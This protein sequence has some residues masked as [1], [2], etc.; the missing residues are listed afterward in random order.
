VDLMC[1]LSVTSPEDHC[2]RAVDIL[3]ATAQAGSESLHLVD[4]ILRRSSDAWIISN[5]WIAAAK[6]SAAHCMSRFASFSADLIAML[7]SVPRFCLVPWIRGS[8]SVTSALEQSS[9]D[10]VA[11]AQAAL[12]LYC[13]PSCRA[14]LDRLR[15]PSSEDSGCL[16]VLTCSMI[17]L[18]F[19]VIMRCFPPKIRL[20]SQREA[21][22]YAHMS[23]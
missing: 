12:T 20:R 7:V 9:A 15:W 6:G 11:A 4:V 19:I 23:L 13:K 8:E 16:T 5:H 21:S 1:F 22:K 10:R 3:V 18:V 2:E 17:P 14:Q